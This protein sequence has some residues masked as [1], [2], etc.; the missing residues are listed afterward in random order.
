MEETI[1]NDIQ[2]KRIEGMAILVVLLIFWNAILTGVII[3]LHKDISELEKMAVVETIQETEVVETTECTSAPEITTGSLETEPTDII[4]T[5]E[6]T[7]PTENDIPETTKPKETKPSANTSSKVVVTDEGAELSIAPPETD[8]EMLACVIYQEA[9]GSA[10]CDECRRRIGDI[11]LNR[12]A[13]ERFPNSIKEVLLQNR[14]YGKFSTTG[15][16]WASRSTNP[17]ERNAVIRAYKAAEDILAG[18]HSD[19]YGKGYVWQATFK[20]GTDR[21]YCCGH[22]F[23][24]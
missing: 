21:F 15:L 7:I 6:E 17:N 2:Q 20:Q 18:N 24:R 11:V 3:G 9:G 23:G 4:P 12:V 16:K 10:H 13:D 19:V 14:Q 1:H 5:T 8:L 22:W